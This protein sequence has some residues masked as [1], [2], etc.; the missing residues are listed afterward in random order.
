MLPLAIE[1]ERDL[2]LN[3][4]EGTKLKVIQKMFDDT[5][6]GRAN[7]PYTLFQQVNINTLSPEVQRYIDHKASDLS[8]LSAI[9]AEYEEL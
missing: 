2:L 4:K 9:D 3:G 6:I 5:G 1:T 8:D 7:T